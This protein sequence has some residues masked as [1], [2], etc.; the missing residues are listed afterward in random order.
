M[1]TMEEYEKVVELV[2]ENPG[3]TAEE[4]G[5]V[6]EQHGVDAATARDLLLE[7]RDAEDVVSAGGLAGEARFWVMRKGKYAFDA[8]DH[9]TTDRLED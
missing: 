4:F 3:L 6:A 1:K 7:A 5:E 8:Y 2:A 9:P